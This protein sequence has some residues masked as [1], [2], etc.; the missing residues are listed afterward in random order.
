M[1]VMSNGLFI[2]LAKMPQ[3]FA[4]HNLIGVDEAKP[5]CGHILGFSDIG[6]LFTLT[7]IDGD[8]TSISAMLL[9]LTALV[10]W[11]ILDTEV[12]QGDIQDFGEA[13]SVQAVIANP[14]SCHPRQVA[15][16]EG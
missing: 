13:F 7:N 15:A 6:K 4:G 10:L 16:R 8:L 5:N 12:L 1:G 2:D 11:M 9:I 3:G 14:S